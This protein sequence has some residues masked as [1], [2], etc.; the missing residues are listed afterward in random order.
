MSPS[1]RSEMPTDSP[2]SIQKPM[3]SSFVRSTADSSIR[4]VSPA[5]TASRARVTDR[6][7]TS[8]AGREA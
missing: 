6:N 2:S 5:G 1:G 3:P 4:A 8:H 7:R